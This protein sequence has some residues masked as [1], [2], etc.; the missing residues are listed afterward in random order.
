MKLVIIIIIIIIINPR[1]FGAIFR[2]L[3]I[4]PSDG[5]LAQR[6]TPNLEEQVI[7]VFFL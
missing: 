3:N 6:L 4:L 7:V 2:I 5:L 1:L